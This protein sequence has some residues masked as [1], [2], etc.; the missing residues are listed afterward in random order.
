MAAAEAGQTAV[1]T[2]LLT[3]KAV[4]NQADS[5]RYPHSHA[6]LRAIGY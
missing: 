5:V 4:V 6:C 1:V 2:L 3:A